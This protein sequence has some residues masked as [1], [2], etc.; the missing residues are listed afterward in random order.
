MQSFIAVQILNS[1]K[2]VFIESELLQVDQSLEALDFLD[3]VILKTKNFYFGQRGKPFNTV[4][5]VVGKI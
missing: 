3:E 5:V 4:D 2:V 1:L